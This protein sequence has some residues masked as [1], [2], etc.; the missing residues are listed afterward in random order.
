MVCDGVFN[1]HTLKEL[2]LQGVEIV[3]CHV[4]ALERGVQKEEGVH[5]SSQ[6]DWAL[7]VHESDR[8]IAFG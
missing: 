8:V 7:I 6:H 3:V 4:S 1:L 5:V 2:V